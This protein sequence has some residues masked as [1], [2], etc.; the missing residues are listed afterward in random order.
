MKIIAIGRNYAAHIEELKNEKP[1]EPVVFGKPETAILR[2]NAPFYLPD[3][4][5]DVHHEVEIVLRIG[6]TGK[7]VESAFAHK[8]IDAV[9]LG[10]DFTAR[11]IQD[12]LKKKGL[13]WEIAKAFDGSAPVSEF[14]PVTDFA[15]LNNLNFSLTVNEELRQKG[16]TNMMIFSFAEIVS[17][18]SRFF[19]LKTG[20]LIFTG[21]P[22]GVAAV[23][24]GD[25]LK[26]FLE[27]KLMFDFEVK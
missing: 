6:K 26:G 10:V 9:G 24:A 4:S 25:R 19:T 7:F 11:D 1:T 3:F 12:Q 17:Y 20:D 16:N 18:V 23:K 8:Y 5:K 13:P 2:Q 22:Q 21:T 15:D 14:L 27:E